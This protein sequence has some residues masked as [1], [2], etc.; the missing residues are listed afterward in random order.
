MM[1]MIKAVFLDL[2]GTI[3]KLKYRYMDAK[4]EVFNMLKLNGVPEHLLD[5]KLSLYEGLENVKNYM[6]S[7]GETH[8]YEQL[9]N[10]SLEIAERY[11][12][13]AASD[14]EILNGTY[15]TLVRLKY[16]GLKLSLITNNCLK[17]TI[18]TI[19]KLNIGEFFELIVARDHVH[20]MKP[21]PAPIRYALSKLNLREDEAVMVGDSTV[22][23]KAALRAG[24]VP[25]GI[26]SG[27]A[28][29]D[30]LMEAG[31][32]YVIDGIWELP[33]LIEDIRYNDV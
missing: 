10:Y 28:T 2:D 19:S 21:N 33:K 22:D 27:V 14:P 13:D 20:A 4:V 32:E 18:L 30:I 12:L 31:A 17:A 26:A 29:R 1:P 16:M 25:I 11:E 7:R 9:L 3:V 6:E 23:V 8:K 5:L 24:I 15:E